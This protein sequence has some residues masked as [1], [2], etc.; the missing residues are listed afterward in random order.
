M[1]IEREVLVNGV[2]AKDTFFWKYLGYQGRVMPRGDGNFASR[3][4]KMLDPTTTGTR[5]DLGFRRD[6]SVL[7]PEQP[8]S[9]YF[10]LTPTLYIEVQG[11]CGAKD[12]TQIRFDYRAR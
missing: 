12:T 10:D 4:V 9:S 5:T 1:R 3:A 6:L 7:G 2:R 8:R 11:L